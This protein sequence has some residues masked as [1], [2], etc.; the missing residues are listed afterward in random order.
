MNP[1]LFFKKV[2]RSNVYWHVLE[3]VGIRENLIKLVILTMREVYFKF[4]LAQNL[5]SKI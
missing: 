2:L 4:R 1:I 5:I 3:D